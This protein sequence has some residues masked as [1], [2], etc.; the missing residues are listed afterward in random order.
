MKLKNLFIRDFGI[1]K[2][3]SMMN[4]SSNIVVIGGKNRAGKSTLMKIIRSIAYGFTNE[5]YLPPAAI[6]HEIEADVLDEYK[7]CYCIRNKGKRRP[8]VSLLSSNNPS[9][10]EDI[11]KIRGEIDYFTYQELFTISLDELQ[12]VTKENENL[13]AILLGAGVKDIMQIPAIVNNYKKDAKKIGGV[14]GN[15]SSALFKDASLKIQEGMDL[16]KKALSQVEQYD[17]NKK[18]LKDLEND[19][20][21][22]Q[23]LM[24]RLNNK[25]IILDLV[26]S[27]YDKHKVI[28]N[29]KNNIDFN[30][31][32]ELRNYYGERIPSIEMVEALSEEYQVASGE[33]K[34]KLRL[35]IDTIMLD[36]KGILSV[37]G[38]K[39]IMVIIDKLL[40]NEETIKENYKD[41]SGIKEKIINYND[42]K[43]YCIE[44]NKRIRHEAGEINEEFINDYSKILEINTDELQYHDLCRIADLYEEYSR[45]L[46]L[47]KNRNEEL[48]R[49]KVLLK[50]EYT[51]SNTVN[52]E[53]LNL[54]TYLAFIFAAIGAAVSFFNIIPGLAL[55]VFGI[56]YV[57]ASNINKVF[58]DNGNK[59]IK[60]NFSFQLKTIDVEINEVDYRIKELGDKL[61]PVD[62]DFT[63]Y[64]A[65]LRLHGDIGPQGIKDYFKA[66]KNI[67]QKINDLKISIEAAENQA[68]EINER[69]EKIDSLCKE[70]YTII[71]NEIPSYNGS[72][73][74]NNY[75]ELLMNVT[76][77]YGYVSDAAEIK[78]LEKQK[79]KLEATIKGYV[80]NRATGDKSDNIAE[81]L[82]KYLDNL[83]TYNDYNEIYSKIN[84]LKLQISASIKSV[85]ARNALEMELGQN[86]T[87]EQLEEGFYK[88]LFQYASIEEINRGYELLVKKL[89]DKEIEFK[90][91]EEHKTHL[92]DEI[93]KL[94]S[95]ELLEKSQV[96]IEQG[97]NELSR[98]AEKFAVYNSAAFLMTKVQEKFLERAKSSLLNDASEVLK[99][100]TSG[101]Y[102]KIEPSENLSSLEFETVMDNGER[103]EDVSVLSRGT[104]EQLFLSVRISR[105]KDIKPSMPVILDDSLVN[106]DKRHLINTIN[107]IND[108]SITNQI[109][110]LTCHPEIIE[111]IENR[112]EEVQ[113]FKVDKGIISSSEYRELK[114]YLE[115]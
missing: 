31:Y 99:E 72:E 11:N 109:F 35:F 68:K 32:K 58:R 74:I 105:I 22:N 25:L 63:N 28:M 77:L 42:D 16:K 1:Y 36:S 86:C 107:V 15:P 66:I 60:D 106:F 90:K 113:Y 104:R 26:R 94:S 79:I 87:D 23:L 49:R 13:Q 97:R 115:K 2:N 98:L 18:L 67:K 83:K 75:E 102:M 10:E 84:S 6:E 89:T 64:K 76:K 111:I 100:I 47:L 5:K 46:A 45:E 71:F 51:K 69:L 34:D 80:K 88:I 65:M 29:L 24:E 27:S 50:D 112:C 62:E 3:Q 9:L 52:K 61:K 85:H 4:I 101:E 7:H 81:N 37:E 30:A 41:L 56:I 40:V 110:I 78:L 92:V 19:I 33:Y 70:F 93:K 95:I 54:Y 44:L 21:D 108:L 55:M 48:M 43:Q 14:A 103:N 91:L 39:E 57:V 114:A 8:Y 53:S 59:S 82:E 12:G 96:L 73:K 20:K 17:E 38:L